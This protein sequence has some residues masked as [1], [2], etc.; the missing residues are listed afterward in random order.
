[1]VH[2]MSPNFVPSL[3]E[4]LDGL[5][6]RL[7]PINLCP[8]RVP[9]S[10]YKDWVSIGD[11]E[12]RGAKLESFKNGSGLYELASKAVVEGER[13]QCGL[14]QVF[15]SSADSRYLS[16]LTAKGATEC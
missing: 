2:A 16:D 5:D 3:D 12:K 6:V 11:Q 9:T 7:I 4:I 15:L 14:C 10:V 1:M 13:N 8:I